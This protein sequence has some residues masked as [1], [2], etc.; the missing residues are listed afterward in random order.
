MVFSRSKSVEALSRQALKAILESNRDNLV[1]RLVKI[2]GIGMNK[3]LALAASIELGRRFN[4]SPQGYLATPTDVI[5][6]I[7]G[8]AMQSQEHFLCISL[9]G[10]REIMTIRVICVGSGNMAV[11]HPAEVF[12]EAIKEHASAIIEIGRAHV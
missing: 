2:K 5:Q 3:A 4:R 6:F 1:E 8:Y 7:Q 11:L 12:C 9:N 10:A